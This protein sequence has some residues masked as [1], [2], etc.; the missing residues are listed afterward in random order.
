M[1]PSDDL[2]SWLNVSRETAQKLHALCDL[3]KRWNPAINLVAKSTVPDLW[4]RHLLDSAQLFAYCP[5]A[6][7]KW[8]DLGSGAGFPGLV[9]AIIAAEQRPDL[10]VTLV[11]SDRRK[12]VFLGEA[13]RLLG[14]SAKIICQRIEDVKPQG[15]DVLSARALAPLA[16]LCGYAHIHLTGGGVAVLPKGA[17]AK[18]EIDDA[19]VR[20]QFDCDSHNSR[21]DPDAAILILKDIRNV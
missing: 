16:V 3:V 4:Q 9:M 13:V 1:T 11:E 15:A 12:S 2:P 10:V 20:W 17:Q 7:K 19:Q 21:T 18:T 8:L 5:S 14:L 6:A